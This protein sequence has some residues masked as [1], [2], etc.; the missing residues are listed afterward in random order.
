[1]LH[2]VGDWPCSPFQGWKW[3][4][5]HSAW[6][7]ASSAARAWASSSPGVNSSVARKKPIRMRGAYPRPAR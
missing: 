6:K 4:E 2:P 1:M 5:I 7:P 3:S